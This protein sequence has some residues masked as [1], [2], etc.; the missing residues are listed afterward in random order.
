MDVNK[1]V[2]DGNEE[3]MADLLETSKQLVSVLKDVSDLQNKA[4]DK[5]SVK[6]VG[7]IR[8]SGFN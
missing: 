5:L 7:S 2:E 1:I 3:I 8:S 6:F 4:M